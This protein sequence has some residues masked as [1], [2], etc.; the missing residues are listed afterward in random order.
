MR[1]TMFFFVSAIMAGPNAVKP[2]LK[3]AKKISRSE[4][5]LGSTSRGKAPIF[6]IK[7]YALLI[8]NNFSSYFLVEL[9][10][11][12]QDY[13]KKLVLIFLFD[14]RVIR[15]ISVALFNLLGNA[16]TRLAGQEENKPASLTGLDIYLTGTRRVSAQL[17][18]KD[19]IWL[20]KN[21]GPSC[22][23]SPVGKASLRLLLPKD[24]T[25]PPHLCAA[26]IWYNS[27][28]KTVI[29]YRIITCSPGLPNAPDEIAVLK[30]QVE[31]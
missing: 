7:Q 14:A 30:K 31:Q 28:Q 16:F 26:K 22:G 1:L 9:I 29:P 18:A 17:R 5:T 3:K 2:I 15:R 10:P 27:I 13:T 4:G 23:K 8:G 19:F 11:I 25:V 20:A 12:P 6:C 21:P 24:L